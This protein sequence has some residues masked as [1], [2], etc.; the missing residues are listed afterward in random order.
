[1]LI[2]AVP[3]RYVGGCVKCEL[4]RQPV[5][6]RDSITSLLNC[7]LIILSVIIFILQYQKGWHF[8]DKQ[9]VLAGIGYRSRVGRSYATGCYFSATAID[10]RVM[11]FDTLDLAKEFIEVQFGEFIVEVYV[12][13]CNLARNI[14]GS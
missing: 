1:M 5:L 10:L 13:V 12:D 14:F 11:R 3:L 7:K 9:Y 4:G 8:V 2:V 6:A